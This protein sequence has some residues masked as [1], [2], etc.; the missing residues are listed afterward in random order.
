MSPAAQPLIY[1]DPCFQK[2]LTGD[3]PESP[4]RLRYLTAQLSSR[5]IWKQ[6]T[7]R[8]IR[9]ATPAEIERVH[10]PAHRR[11]IRDSC[12]LH[13][14][15][16][17]ADTV[18][19]ADSF[20]VALQAAG[21][22]VAAVDAVI[23]GPSRRALCLSRPPGHHALATAP[24]GF[25]LFNNLAVAAAH[26]RDHHR[27]GRILI[28]DIDFHHGNVTHDIL[29]ESPDDWFL[30]VHR[31]PFY[32]GTGAA[33]ETGR[34]AGLGTTFNLPLKYGVSRQDFRSQ[35]ESI[36]EQAASR[37][38]PEL[39]LLSAGFDAHAADPVGDLGLETEDFAPLT[40]AVVDIAAQH[41]Q[42]KLVSLL[43]GGYHIQHLAESVACHM[44]TLA[45][46]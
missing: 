1:T 19:S 42:G 43:E 39:V 6:F 22:A 40:Q 45:K 17:E 24:M 7:S 29:Y 9:A 28:V 18:V 38:K 8:E 44:E 41:A 46:S 37:C 11:F 34:G 3:H 12:Q 20:T 14:G 33:T 31:S 23:A 32:P 36:L 35:F 10:S 26:A 4:E 27:L 13:P 25:C 16:I 30:S 15:R 5:P 21:S 2:H